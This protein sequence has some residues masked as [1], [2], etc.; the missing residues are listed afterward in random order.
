MI[1]LCSYKETVEKKYKRRNCKRKA[2]LGYLGCFSAICYIHVKCND[3]T[4]NNVSGHQPH[5]NNTELDA[6]CIRMAF[7]WH[8]MS[9]T[10]L[11]CFS[12]TFHNASRFTKRIVS[13][14]KISFKISSLLLKHKQEIKFIP[15]RV[16]TGVYMWDAMPD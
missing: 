9:L 6:L 8:T 10:K 14:W 16:G 3:T 11:V 13:L 4:R 7:T 1:I 12:S 5:S 2:Y 15:I